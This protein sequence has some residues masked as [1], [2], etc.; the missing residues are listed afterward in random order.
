MYNHCLV[1]VWTSYRNIIQRSSALVYNDSGSKRRMKG[2]TKQMSRKYA[3]DNFQANMRVL[4]SCFCVKRVE[5]QR[6]EGK[7][8]RSGNVR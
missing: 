2:E 1:S 6:L 7:K 8:V 3:G 4:N 5:T